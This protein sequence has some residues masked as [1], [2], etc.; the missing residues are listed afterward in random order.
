M[1]KMLKKFV[2]RII[3]PF[4]QYINMNSFVRIQPS[5]VKD[6]MVARSKIQSCEYIELNA[7]QANIFE[8]RLQLHDMAMRILK[9]IKGFV[10]EFG[11]YQG[12][13]LN[14][15]AKSLLIDNRIIYGFDSFQGLPERWGGQIHD[16]GHF[17]LK[18]RGLPAVDQN[19]KLIPGWFD[20]SFPS[21]LKQM[22]VDVIA[23]IHFDADLYSSTKIVLD[24]LG[25]RLRKGSLV[26]FD[27][28][29]GYPGWKNHEFKAFQEFVTKNSINYE[30]LAFSDIQCL[31]QIK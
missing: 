3:V 8:N 17:D 7:E 23:F 2:D 22:D 1:K 6:L 10:F 4:I 5:T 20:E 12:E 25:N 13:S 15:F 26:L 16:K 21:F 14:Y 29:H 30:Y 28:Y 31:I 9:D 11:V 18:K 19:V 24:L 27:E